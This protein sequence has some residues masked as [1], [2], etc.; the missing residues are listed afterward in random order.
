MVQVP[1]YKLI[2]IIVPF[3][4]FVAGFCFSIYIMFGLIPSDANDPQGLM[5][6]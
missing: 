6:R 4:L 2:V 5:R 1:K 3:V